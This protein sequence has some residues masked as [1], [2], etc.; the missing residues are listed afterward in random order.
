MALHHAD[1]T[2]GREVLEDTPVVHIVDDDEGVR[3]SLAYLLQS[4]GIVALTYPDAPSFLGE[5]D[6]EEPAV[7]ILELRMRGLS[8]L[9]LQEQLLERDY[10]A[11]VLFCSGHGNVPSAVRA[12]RAGAVGFFE[13]PYEPQTMVETVQ[14]QLSAARDAFAARSARRELSARLHG[15]TPRER[16]VLRLVMDGLSSQ[17]IAT[18]LSASVKT[19][20]V[21]RT[22][23]RA[24]TSAE[25]LGRLVRDLYLHRLTV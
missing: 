23:I 4:V 20:D 18:R 21:H 7:V 22:R 16:D 1:L 15:L 19:V 8:G 3:N 14:A 17:Q 10:P 5:F 2:P 24:K 25:S 6:E 12:M 9:L 13:K 11:P